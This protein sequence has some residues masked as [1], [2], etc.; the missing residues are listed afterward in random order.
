MEAVF[1]LAREGLDDLFAA[2]RTAGYAVLGPRR[3]DGVISLDSLEDSGDLP[4][5]VSDRQEPGSYRLETGETDRAFFWTTTA[6]GIKP[7]C[8]AP[9]EILWNAQRDTSGAIRFEPQQAPTPKIAVLGVRACDLAGLQLQDRHFQE[10]GDTW[11]ARRREN[12][13]LVAVNCA[14]AGKTCFC[15]ST[16]D[17]PAAR[18]GYDLLLDELDA[19]FLIRAGSRTGAALLSALDTRGA[20]PDQIGQARNQTLSA[21]QMQE[22]RLPST[23][24][25]ESIAARRGARAWDSIAETCL[26]CGNCTSVCPSCF[27]HSHEEETELGGRRSTHVRR[28]D[29][30]F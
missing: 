1:Y 19:G 29:S 13:L 15:A 2:L 21:A 16:G 7:L 22:R 3:Q 23:D 26:A 4:W 24:L 14:R 10:R 12:L 30:C 8:F 17:G 11:Y 9:R 18:D 25:Q 20:T 6:Q 5:G 27:C 28:W